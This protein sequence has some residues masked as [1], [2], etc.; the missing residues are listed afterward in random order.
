MQEKMLV[1]Y[2]NARILITDQKLE[3]IKDV[4]PV[5][6]QV[7]RVNQPL[8]IIAED[9][10]GAPAHLYFDFLPFLISFCFF[11]DSGLGLRVH[12][13]LA[14]YFEGLWVFNFSTV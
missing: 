5:L 13:Y 4:L 11:K 9:V 7:T 12:P 1:E 8:V 2:E 6:E 14:P 10:T 3:T